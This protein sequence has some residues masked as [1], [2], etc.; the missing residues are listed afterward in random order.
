[1]EGPAL[2]WTLSEVQLLRLRATFH[3]LRYF[4]NPRKFYTRKHEK[5]KKKLEIHLKADQTQSSDQLNISAAP[6]PPA[7]LSPAPRKG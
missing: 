5:I 7:T 3:T 2:K 6:P 4:T 1:M